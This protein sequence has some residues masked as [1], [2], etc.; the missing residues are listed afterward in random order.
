MLGAGHSKPIRRL[1]APTSAPD[2]ETKWITLDI[3]S[4]AKPDFIFDLEELEK[5]KHLPVGDGSIDEIHAYEI[6]EHFGRQGD[7][8]G[9]FATFRAF[10]Q[11]LNLDG[12]VLG[13][14][15]SLQ[16]KWAWGDPGHTRVLSENSFSFLRKVHYEQLGQTASSDYR[17]YVAPYWWE[18]D[19][20]L[21]D[22][23]NFVFALR[24][25]I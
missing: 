12:L 10:W 17:S 14:C 25:V 23:N 18:L 7:F 9:F 19:H 13:T 22:G 4:K 8:R 16:S 15:P 21:D 24:K 1:T 6:L 20:S 3:N 5:G 2:F 11:A